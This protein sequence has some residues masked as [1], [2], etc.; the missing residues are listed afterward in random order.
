MTND[1]IHIPMPAIQCNFKLKTLHEEVY[2]GVESVTLDFITRTVTLVVREPAVSG[3]LEAFAQFSREQFFIQKT[4]SHGEVYSTIRFFGLQARSHST[5]L[6]YADHDAV[7]HTIVFTY[8]SFV[9]LDPNCD[10]SDIALDPECLSPAD[11]IKEI[12]NGM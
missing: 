1:Q 4:N 11:A 6:A 12:D 2:R 3:A 10:S 7:R 9:E 5:K 8:D